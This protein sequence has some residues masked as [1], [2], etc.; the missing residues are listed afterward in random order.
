MGQISRGFRNG[1]LAVT[2]LALSGCT[3]LTGSNVAVSQTGDN[4]A[5]TVVP[6][7]T[8]PED[9]VI[10]RREHPRIIAAYGGVYSDRPAE[11]MVARIVSRLLAAANQPNAQFQVTILDSSEVNAFA[12]P[13]GYI[14]VTRGI[15]ALAS[16][17]SE[18]AAV[19][20]HEIAHVT[21]RH[22]RAR[23]DRTRTT[24]I[25]D[26]VITGVFGGDTSTDATANRT[27]QSMAAFS[28]NQ[29]LDADREGIKFAGKAGYD[30]QAAARFL[31]VMSRFASFSAGESGDDGFLSSH[32]STPARI[33]KAVD[34]AR[35]MFGQ[36]SL[37]TDR[38]G[39][40]ASIAGLTFG[41]S[42]AQGSIVGRRFIHTASKFTF[43]VPAGYTLQNSQSAVVGVAGDGEAVRFDSADVQANVP[44]SD[45]LKS[46]WIAG[47]KADSVTTQSFNGIDM[48]SGLAQTD[49]WFF[50]VSV[51]RL[52]GQVYRFI[53]AAKS[54]SSRFA[55]G[56]EETLKSFRRAEASDLN[57][58]RKVAVRV[59][60]A[61][62]GDSA[63]SL[64]RQMAGL[65]RGSELFY[66]INDLYP[67]D[68]VVPGEK[69]KVVVLQ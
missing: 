55:Q 50:R 8:D 41:D 18:L 66:I 6:E 58:V 2:L 27:R 52:D 42:P 62:S 19:L 64:A 45:Y 61:R 17:T 16:D 56:A 46:G 1:L 34:T 67:G 36:A 43:T 22:A 10:G 48:A 68:A 28:Q 33:Q 11:I 37:E 30:P 38:D 21:L 39:Y 12:L 24:E 13:G 51:M 54:D 47:L 4:P 59:V 60:T 26:R 49:Q 65:S 53:F 29:E 57:Q 32:P 31:G 9:V 7:G 3:S 40:L 14:Y 25:V 23:T 63:D 69:Y 5:P 35:T 20:A 44:L 15:L